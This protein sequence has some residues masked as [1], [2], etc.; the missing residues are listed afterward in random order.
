MLKYRAVC[1][2]V[3]SGESRE[4]T[5]V[6]EELSSHA[7]LTN[8]AAETLYGSGHTFKR[9]SANDIRKGDITWRSPDMTV[10]VDSVSMSIRMV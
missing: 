1:V 3:D 6:M 8:V 10:H 4:G 5:F 9:N 7:T 2:S